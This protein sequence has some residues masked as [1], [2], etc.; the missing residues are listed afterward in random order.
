MYKGLS[1]DNMLGKND[2]KNLYVCGKPMRGYETHD[3]RFE[4][5]NAEPDCSTKVKKT[6][7]PHWTHSSPGTSKTM[8]FEL[9]SYC[10]N[11]Y[12]P[13][14]DGKLVSG[15]IAFDSAYGRNQLQKDDYIMKQVG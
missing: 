11:S 8:K 6:S 9:P 3:M 2:P 5:L 12:K 7:L 15:P 4:N 13:E 1:F 10:N 14:L